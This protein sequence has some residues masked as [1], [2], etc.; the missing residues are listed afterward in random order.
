MLAGAMARIYNEQCSRES[1]YLGIAETLSMLAFIR[2]HDFWLETNHPNIATLQARIHTTNVDS[3]DTVCEIKWQPGFITVEGVDKITRAGQPITFIPRYYSAAGF[4]QYNVLFSANVDWLVYDTPRASFVG[5]IPSVNPRT[6]LTLTIVIKG[7]F[8]SGFGNARFERT[9]RARLKVEVNAAQHSMGDTNLNP[10]NGFHVSSHSHPMRGTTSESEES[11]NPRP[12]LLDLLAHDITDGNNTHVPPPEN[13]DRPDEIHNAS[14]DTLSDVLYAHEAQP[15]RI[16]SQ[17]TATQ[18]VCLASGR[19]GCE[20]GTPANTH[21][22]IHENERIESYDGLWLHRKGEGIYKD[23]R[24]EGFNGGEQREEGEQH[25]NADEQGSGN[26][27]EHSSD[28]SISGSI[29]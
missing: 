28:E 5:V 17:R 12:N 20:E 26:E 10:S 2:L 21:F 24:G 6:G 19:A 22:S 13:G 29:W 14:D 11:S 9:T 4:L 23:G 7:V 3:T 16:S 15:R 27:S 1:D 8:T 25:C 18:E